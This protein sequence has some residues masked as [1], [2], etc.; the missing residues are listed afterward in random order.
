M[1]QSRG[2]ALCNSLYLLRKAKCLFCKS[3]VLEHNLQVMEHSMQVM[4]QNLQGMLGVL[5]VVACWLISVRCKCE[6]MHYVYQVVE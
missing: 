4:K 3:R 2:V 6:V 1:L 5:H